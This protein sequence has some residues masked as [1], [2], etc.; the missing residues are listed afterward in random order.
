[1]AARRR[2][3]QRRLISERIA[4]AA[5][6]D[7]AAIGSIPHRRVAAVKPAKGVGSGRGGIDQPA[8][9]RRRDSARPSVVDETVVGCQRHG[10]ARRA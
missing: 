7:R 6:A 3:H 1:M 10:G 9:V 2:E 4:I 5:L 8:T